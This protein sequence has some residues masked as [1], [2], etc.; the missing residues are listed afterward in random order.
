VRASRAEGAGDAGSRE[1]PVFPLGMTA[2]PS[3]PTSL[4]IF[5]ARYRLLSTALGTT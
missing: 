2:F 4:H 3:V 5:E 1:L